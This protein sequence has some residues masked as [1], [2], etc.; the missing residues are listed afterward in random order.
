MDK[1]RFRLYEYLQDFQVI[2]VLNDT[3]LL[4]HVKIKY[5]QVVPNKLIGSIQYYSLFVETEEI[6]A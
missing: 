6:D 1:R 4:E 5:W 2:K 3:E